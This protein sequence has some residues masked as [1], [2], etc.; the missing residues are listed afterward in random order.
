MWWLRGLLGQV[1]ARDI[2]GHVPERQRHGCCTLL[3]GVRFAGFKC[4]A[5]VRIA[6]PSRFTLLVGKNASGKSSVLDG[7]HLASQL[8]I[9]VAGERQH[10][11]GRAGLVF[12]GAYDPERLATHGHRALHVWL[13]GQS[14][15]ADVQ[16]HVSA[17]DLAVPGQKP[18]RFRAEWHS[19][20]G[21]GV[22]NFDRPELGALDEW[23]RSTRLGSVVRLRLSVTTARRPS[24]PPSGAIPR[25][26][27][28]GASLASTLA[29]LAGN[30]RKTLQAIEESLASVV[31][32][33]GTITTPNADVAREYEE[34]VR[35]DDDVVPRHRK[36]M[37]VGHTFAVDMPGMEAVPADLLSDGTVLALASSPCSTVRPAHESCCSTT[38]MPPSIRRRRW[39]SW[40]LSG[41]CWPPSP[42]Y[43]SSLR[44]TRRICSMS[45][46][47]VT[48][49]FCPRTRRPDTRARALSRSTLA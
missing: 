18:D 31:P 27:H 4:L 46:S 32:G 12:R 40:T 34:Y 17:G 15:G 11:H 37:L 10:A 20:S 22:L 14:D 6:F 28:D 38:S 21:T 47:R 43:R 16:L 9:P 23:S 45:S 30:Q 49:S 24:L 35:I 26:E 42:T 39:R 1:S 44:R 48:S 13:G 8:L 41:G 36:D 3:T 7:I 5:D 33:A 29:W 25:V 2:V 19:A